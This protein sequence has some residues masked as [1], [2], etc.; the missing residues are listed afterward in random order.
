MNNNDTVASRL[1]ALRIENQL[2]LTQF[3]AKA[4]GVTK[5]SVQSWE[6]GYSVPTLDKMVLIAKAFNV[7]IDFLTGITDSDIVKISKLDQEQKSIIF[8]MINYFEKIND[9]KDNE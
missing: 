9:I 8:T 6:N 1:R 2:S 7:S 3:G 5:G 4:G